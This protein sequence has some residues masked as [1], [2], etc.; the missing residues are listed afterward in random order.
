MIAIH[1]R[2]NHHN[3]ES[4]L[5]FYMLPSTTAHDTRLGI[6]NAAYDIALSVM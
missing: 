2:V 3:V 6:L 5:F 1:T 4:P